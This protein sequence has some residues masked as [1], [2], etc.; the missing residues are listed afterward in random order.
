[1]TARMSQSVVCPILIGRAGCLATLE[2]VIS[3]AWDGHGNAARRV[4]LEDPFNFLYEILPQ[5]G[6]AVDG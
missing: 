6:P 5:S 2:R 4:P 1:M 3:Q